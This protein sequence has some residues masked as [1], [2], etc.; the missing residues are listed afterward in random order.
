MSVMSG[1]FSF[2]YTAVLRGLG[3]CKLLRAALEGG[4]LNDPGLIS[5]LLFGFSR[6]VNECVECQLLWSD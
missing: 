6:A 1:F 2:F 4:L 5:P 3:I